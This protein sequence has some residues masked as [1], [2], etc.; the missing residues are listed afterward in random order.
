M[1]TRFKIPRI[2]DITM[3]RRANV[4]ETHS[5]EVNNKHRDN[6]LVKYDQNKNKIFLEGGRAS[7]QALDRQ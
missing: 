2:I 1:P 5:M 7:E 6:N 4:S 3:V